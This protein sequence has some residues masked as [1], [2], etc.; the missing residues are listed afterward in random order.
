MNNKHYNWRWASFQDRFA[1]HTI[2]II[3]HHCHHDYTAGSQHRGSN[4]RGVL[5]GVAALSRANRLYLL[6]ILYMY[7][8]E[9]NCINYN[10]KR[11]A[12]W[13]YV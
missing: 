9:T 12:G 11:F 2:Y 10:N 4:S 1:R 5:C 8:V 6:Y 13:L 7:Y 3:T